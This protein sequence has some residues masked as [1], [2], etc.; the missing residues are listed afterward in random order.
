M[1]A[2]HAARTWED[3]DRIVATLKTLTEEETLVVQSGKPVG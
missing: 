1:G 3:F 2:E